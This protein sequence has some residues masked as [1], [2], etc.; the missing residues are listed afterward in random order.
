[1]ATYE[2]M[3]K[4]QTGPK[5]RHK[6]KIRAIHADVIGYNMHFGDQTTSSGIIITNDDGKTRGI[7]PRWCQVYRKGPEN[8]DPYEIDDW[9][10]VAHGRWGRGMILEQEDGTEIEIRKIDTEE[11]LCMSKERPS[12]INLGMEY[13]DN[14]APTTAR[15]EDFGAN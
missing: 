7:Y 4:G 2:E 14:I 12:E 6:G 9:I 5:S 11:I 10:L 3:M 13:G 15:P 8:N 1:M